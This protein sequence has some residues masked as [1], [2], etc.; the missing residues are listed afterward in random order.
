[1]VTPWFAAGAGI[2]IAAA[3]AV[4]SPAALTYGPISPGLRCAVRGC[5]SP[6]PSHPSVLAT[7]TPGAELATPAAPGNG[8]AAA[9]P[10]IPGGSRG[11]GVGYQLGYQIISRR[12]SGFIAVIT[13]PGDGKPGPW[14]L[15]FVFASARVDQVWGASWQPSG[16]GEGGTALGP[17][18]WLW[19]TPGQR[20]WDP[21]QFVV[22]VTGSP[23]SPSGCTL[24]GVSCSF[25]W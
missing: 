13:L 2:V 21:R 6:A 7:A 1:M 16:S 15:R 18:P 4:D 8:A 22:S 19:D 9:R 20:R 11:A 3:L 25:S 24:D 17:L 5:A 10:R 14:S 12:P 23:T